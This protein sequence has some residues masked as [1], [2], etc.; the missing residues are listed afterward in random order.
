MVFRG[1]MRYITMQ[2]FWDTT[3]IAMD[4]CQ[5]FH[6]FETLFVFKKDCLCPVQSLSTHHPLNPGNPSIYL[7]LQSDSV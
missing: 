3:A 7:D 5:R 6:G 1:P 4:P 2:I